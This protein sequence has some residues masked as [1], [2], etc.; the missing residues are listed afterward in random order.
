MNFS[1]KNKTHALEALKK[2]MMAGYETTDRA[3]LMEHTRELAKLEL[4]QTFPAYA[5]AAHYVHNLMLENGIASEYLTFP[6]DGKTAYE[7]K[8]MPIAWDASVGKLTIVNSP[9]SFENPVIADYEEMPLHLIKHSVSTPEGGIVTRLVAESAVYAGED[10]T[11]AMVLLE[12]ESR[13]TSATIPP[14]LDLGAIGVVSDYLVGAVDTPDE[15][16]WANAATDADGWHVTANDRDFIG[17]QITPRTGRK[18]RQAVTI[19]DV[20]VRIECDGKRYVGELPAVT[21]LIPGKQKREVWLLAHLY[22]PFEID[23][24]I[25]VISLIYAVKKVQE[26]IDQGILPPLQFSLRL[27]FAMEHYGFAAV[28]EHFGGRLHDRVWGAFN[29]D[30]IFGAKMHEVAVFYAPLS[31][32]FYGNFTTQ[33]LSTIYNQTFDGPH[34][35]DSYRSFHDDMLLSDSTN[36]LPT[37]WPAGEHENTHHNSIWNNNFL[38]EE[39][40]ARCIGY[41][42]AWIGSNAALDEESL[43]T[44]LMASACLA[45]EF[46][47]EESKKEPNLGSPEEKMEFLTQAM[48]DALRNFKVA[49]NLPIIDEVADSLT[50][51]AGTP[52]AFEESQPWLDYADTII[53]SRLQTGLPFDRVKIPPEQ[54]IAMPGSI[55][56]GYPAFVLS[57]MDGKKTLKRAILETSWQRDFHFTENDIKKCVLTITHLADWGYVSLEEKAPLNQA[58]IVEALKDLGIC[59][60]DVLLVHSGLSHLGHIEG[61][62]NTILDALTEA[63]GEEGTILMPCFTRPYIGFEGSVNKART[64]RPFS[65]HDKKNIWTGTI[66]KTL[67]Q[68]EGA[69]RSANAS[70]SWCGVGKNVEYC[71]SAHERLDPPASKNSPM[72]KALELGGKV[73]FFGCGIASNTFLHFL[74]D[75]VDAPFLLNAIV[76]VKDEDGKIHTEVM[77]KHLPGHRSFYGS[78]PEQGKFYQEA[79]RRGLQVKE[80]SLGLGKLHLMDL[81]QLYEIGMNMFSEDPLATLCDNPNCSFCRNY[82]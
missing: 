35:R 51:P 81:K 4:P 48:K 32:P 55:I 26:L 25:G 12:P 24:S 28:A 74:E 43:P 16:Y 38:D 62:A 33:L 73:L 67:L 15:L 17:F 23:N 36:G 56:Y 65:V 42:T 52:R 20:T 5:D 2:I 44:Y 70:H 34:L 50:A 13:P 45:Q 76:K 21:G 82:R 59:K 71:L 64:F 53:P 19:G 40:Y 79:F 1:Y 41:L 57:A 39:N 30:S 72:A 29:S 68:R 49:V 78:A 18:L 3:W 80:T 58:M 75:Q 54:R 77:K 60:G 66:S 22:E 47:E 10:C 63:V 46:L 31:V 9:I 61:G 37:V 14:L 8:C 69:L 27:V 11:G 7:D 6:A